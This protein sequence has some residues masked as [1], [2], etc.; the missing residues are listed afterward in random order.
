M[1][2]LHKT[3][4][5]D[6]ARGSLIQYIAGFAFSLLLTMTAYVLV[7]Q[8]ILPGIYMMLA[9]A[10]LAIIQLLVQLLFFLHLGRESKPRWNLAVFTFAL[11][12]VGILVG[13]SL[14]IMNNLDYHMTMTPAETDNYI[15][16]DEGVR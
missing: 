8:Q 5:S 1:N 12:V 16:H 15:I 3:D 7:V 13:G 11:I 10:G 4:A 14:W 2:A 9:I 6:A